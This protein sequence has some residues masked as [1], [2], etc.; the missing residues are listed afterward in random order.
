[1][2]R[3]RSVRVVAGVDPGADA[4]CDPDSGRSVCARCRPAASP[5]CRACGRSAISTRRR[6]RST[7]RPRMTLRAE[8]VPDMPPPL[9]P[10]AAR[11]LAHQADPALGARMRRRMRSAVRSARRRRRLALKLARELARVARS[12]DGGRAWRGS[13]CKTIVPERPVAALGA[14]GS[15]PGDPDRAVAGVAGGGEGVRSG[16]ASRRGACGWRRSVGRRRRRAFR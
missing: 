5:C 15:V 3:R 9:S 6:R 11:V 4:A 2:A 14:D 1:M 12:G 7:I 8:V 13:G 16:D 10:S